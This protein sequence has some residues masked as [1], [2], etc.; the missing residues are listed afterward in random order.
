M[1][2]HYKSDKEIE[3][4]FEAVVPFQDDP[5][6]EHGINPAHDCVNRTCLKRYKIDIFKKLKSFIECDT[7]RV[8]SGSP[9]LCNGCLH[10]R[11]VI[12]LYKKEERDKIIQE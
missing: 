6:C 12:E 7:R 3:E 2:N 5:E 11:R 4:E 8:K 10:N 9:I 1:N